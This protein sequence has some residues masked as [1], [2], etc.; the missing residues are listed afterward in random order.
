MVSRPR[1]AGRRGLGGELGRGKI[2]ALT[3]GV[4]LG[5]LAPIILYS[6][7]EPLAKAFN[8]DFFSGSERRAVHF[9]VRFHNC[10][11]KSN[12][13]EHYSQSQPVTIKPISS[14]PH[15]QTHP[16]TDNRAPGI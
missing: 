12:N 1:Q 9:S 5:V 6:R 3:I 8:N 2:Q 13:H 10:W 14:P 4:G 15:S 16:S 7:Q 11:L